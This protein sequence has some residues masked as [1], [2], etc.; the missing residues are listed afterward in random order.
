MY[1][2]WW[3]RADGDTEDTLFPLQSSVSVSS[4]SSARADSLLA[5]WTVYIILGARDLT[6]NQTRQFAVIEAALVGGLI[7]IINLTALIKTLT[8]YSWWCC[9]AAQPITGF[10]F[11]NKEIYFIG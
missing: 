1:S 9:P 4:F 2:A 7:A 6:S 8:V 5:V 11:G 10:I 3:W